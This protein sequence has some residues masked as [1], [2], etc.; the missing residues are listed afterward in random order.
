MGNS[1]CQY[2]TVLH[3]SPRNYL[4]G[5]YTIGVPLECVQAFFALRIP[6]LHH[7]VIR[8]TYYKASIILNTSYSC[9]VAH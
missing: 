6:D 4:K 8:S 9:K 3:E 2:L 5:I 1:N 7:V